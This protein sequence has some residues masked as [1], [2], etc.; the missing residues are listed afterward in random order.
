MDF[1]S[2]MV[3]I[4]LGFIPRSLKDFKI[5]ISHMVQI[6]Q[7]GKKSNQEFKSALY[8]TWFRLNTTNTGRII[9]NY[10][11]FISHMVQ[12][13]RGNPATINV[14]SLLYIPHGSD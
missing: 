4:K 13:K 14:Q 6:K 12:I 3:Q 11:S 5:F 8:P 9:V 2:H 7:E 1:I 10:P